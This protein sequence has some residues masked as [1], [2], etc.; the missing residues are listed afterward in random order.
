MSSS[1][2]QLTIHVAEFR[3]PGVHHNFDDSDSGYDEDSRI[4]NFL[5]QTRGGRIIL[6]GD[7]TEILT[8]SDDTEMFDHI[9]EDKDLASQVNKSDITEKVSNA[10]GVDPAETRVKVIGQKPLPDVQDPSET[11]QEE[12]TSEKDKG[13]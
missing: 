4:K 6:L 9:E 5:N 11:K 8:D 2:N 3:G 1:A 13:K 10:E 12:A 7:G